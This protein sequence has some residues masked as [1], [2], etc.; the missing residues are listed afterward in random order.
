MFPWG[1][2]TKSRL[3]EDLNTTCPRSEPLDVWDLLDQVEHG[4][5]I[6][7]SKIHYWWAGVYYWNPRVIKAQ[8]THLRWICSC[9]QASSDKQT[10]TLG[11]LR[12]WRRR[13]T[14]TWCETWLEYQADHSVRNTGKTLNTPQNR[15]KTYKQETA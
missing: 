1:S 7:E 8:P 13:K 15:Q 11:S 3:Q 9:R 12:K 6:I 14:G 5:T 2:A 10:K 4:E